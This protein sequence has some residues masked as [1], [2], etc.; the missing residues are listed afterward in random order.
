MR[1]VR[2][3]GQRMSQQ[4][5]HETNQ[6]DED[7]Q[8]KGQTQTLFCHA[9]RMIMM[10]VMGMVMGR[11]LY[12]TFFHAST[13]LYLDLISSSFLED[14]CTSDCTISLLIVS[15]SDYLDKLSLTA[16]DLQSTTC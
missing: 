2:N 8:E 9:M 3:Q 13:S 16:S 1:G 5:T 7:G 10:A 14:T 12:T 6:Q 11:L 15:I 4:S